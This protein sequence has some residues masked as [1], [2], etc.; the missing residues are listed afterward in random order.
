MNDEVTMVSDRAGN[1]LLPSLVA[2]NDDQILVGD[3][4]KPQMVTNAENSIYHVK[5]V[6][7]RRFHD[8]TVYMDR[9]L[10]PFKLVDIG[11]NQQIKIRVRFNKKSVYFT[12]EEISAY[13]LKRLKTNCECFLKKKSIC[14]VVIGVPA[15]FTNN[16]KSATINA[17]KIAGFNVKHIINEPTAA[18]LAYGFGRDENDK[19]IHTLLVYD[20]GGGTFD[21]SILKICGRQFDVVAIN[22]DNHLGGEDFITRIVNHLFK[23][24]EMKFKIKKRS[25]QMIYRLRQ[26]SE[27]AMK[28]L[29]SH[30]S[31]IIE[32][33]YF[34][35]DDNREIVDFYSS[36]TREK[37][38]EINKD[39]FNMMMELVS[40][41]LTD[42]KL[43]T[44]DIEKVLLVGGPTKIPRIQ[45]LLRDKFGEGKVDASI[46]A[47]EAVALGAAVESAIL[48]GIKSPLL[49]NVKLN[50]VTPISLGMRV[51]ADHRM[52]KFINRNTPTPF[53]YTM[54]IQTLYDN[55]IAVCFAIFE[56]ENEFTKD[57]IYLG[58]FFI[59]NLPRK[60]AG[61][62]KFDTTFHLNENGILNVTAQERET[63][64]TGRIR[65]QNNFCRLTDVEV[66]DLRKESAEYE[67]IG[68]D[69]RKIRKASKKRELEK[70]RE[71]VYHF[72]LQ[73]MIQKKITSKVGRKCRGKNEDVMILLSNS[74][75]RKCSIISI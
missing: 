55:Q 2:F 52:R 66:E 23:E 33:D 22:G 70:Y 32:L 57:N 8:N 54:A 45:K 47:E 48:A 53:E 16:M 65:I 49:K 12:P 64:K 74:E 46:N 29:S 24:F 58:E 38:E 6:M 11:H 50:E 19:K 4:V 27:I 14:D 34:C 3:I 28:K 35:T 40:K 51:N 17:G 9:K 63:K 7:G 71:D 36:I 5:R 73:E 61:E 56:G 72:L 39:L 62:V 1:V 43:S 69:E 37:F 30:S 25:N 44:T 15:Y 41:C 42:A 26:I 10:W 13:I 60:P 31:A 20:L 21:L 68:A 18:A 75:V 67:K 59:R